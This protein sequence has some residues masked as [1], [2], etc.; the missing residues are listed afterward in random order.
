[1]VA[2]LRVGEGRRGEFWVECL[3]G[4]PMERFVGEEVRDDK[5]LL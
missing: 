1:M 4:E 5:G 2:C 3:V